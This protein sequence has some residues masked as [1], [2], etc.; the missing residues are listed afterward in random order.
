MTFGENDTNMT[1]PVKWGTNT[2][3]DLGARNIDQLLNKPF[4]AGSLTGV[5][6]AN[7]SFHNPSLG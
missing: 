3:G 7:P 4:Y 2:H 1:F 5:V 6:W